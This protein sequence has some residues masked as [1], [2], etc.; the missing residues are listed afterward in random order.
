MVVTSDHGES[1]GD[2]NFL[3]HAGISVY[4]DQIHIPLIIKYP[5]AV[6]KGVVEETASLVDVA[7]TVL[8]TLGIPVPKDLPGLSLLQS[9]PGG[10]RLVISESFPNGLMTKLHPRFRR[11]ERAAYSGALKLITSTA[12][13]RELY[14]FADDPSE[15]HDL[16]H[17]GEQAG[18]IIETRL[19]AWTEAAQRAAK[20]RT[21]SGRPNKEAL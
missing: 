16:Y 20:S 21:G 4:Q 11:T 1:L 10:D 17:A 8:E 9:A 7:P 12:G 5:G 18:G 2:R 14:R 6:R 13:K 3:E 15:G 19:A